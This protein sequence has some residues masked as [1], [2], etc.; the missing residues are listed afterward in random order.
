MP[1]GVAAELVV[2]AAT[3]PAAGFLAGSGLEPGAIV[4]I[5]ATGGGGVL[6][7]TAG[8]QVHL[9][10]T[11]AAAILVRPLGGGDGT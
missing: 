3:G 6:L 2:V 11:T 8:G 10:E 4:E 7:D 9:V 5:L 1:A